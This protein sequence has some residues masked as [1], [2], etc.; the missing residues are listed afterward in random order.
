M[1]VTAGGPLAP[2][3]TNG[4]VLRSSKIDSWCFMKIQSLKLNQM[5]YYIIS[6]G[7]IVLGIY[8]ASH[9]DVNDYATDFKT[10]LINRL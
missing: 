5:F 8:F 10:P 7:F 4:Q 6:F 3:G 9:Y 1:S 2:V